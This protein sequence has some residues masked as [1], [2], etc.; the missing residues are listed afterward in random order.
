M[1]KPPPIANEEFRLA[2]LH[3]L[4]LLDTPASQSLDRV[5]QELARMLKAPVALVSLVDAERQWFMSRVG[6]QAQQ[7]PRDVA[8]CAHVVAA[9]APLLV[10]DAC[11]DPRFADNPLV[12]AEPH[13]RAYMGVPL[14]APGGLPIGTLCVLDHQPRAFDSAQLNLL[15]RVAGFVEMLL[16]RRH[17]GHGS[18]A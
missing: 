14:H 6:L 18:Q 5:T 9:N 16:A 4:G 15:R 13:L 10:P 2:A 1:E 3:A 17:G 8:F 12:T 11:L 7:T